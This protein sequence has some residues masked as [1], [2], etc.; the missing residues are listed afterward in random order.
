M[1][2]LGVRDMSEE[3]GKKR[4]GR[5]KTDAERLPGSKPYMRTKE[6]AEAVGPSQP[7][8][9]GGLRNEGVLKGLRGY[10]GKTPVFSTKDICSLWMLHAMVSDPDGP[11][12]E[13]WFG[14]A[15]VRHVRDRTSITDPETG[16]KYEG[17]KMSEGVVFGLLDDWADKGYA[18]YTEG[19]TSKFGTVQ[20]NYRLTANGQG[21]Y[22]VLRV[23][24]A[25]NVRAIAFM[26]NA[27]HA[28]LFG[29]GLLGTP[30]PLGERR[31][32]D[33]LDRPLPMP[34]GTKKEE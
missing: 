9:R 14:R 28:D 23:E 33:D 30:V 19:G 31:M 7:G 25:A 13:G 27:L 24:H 4:T 5:R 17:Y 18:T 11:E 6:A 21:Y 16:E 1:L 12:G 2:Y 3:Q 26:M 22:N 10:Q 15:L 29:F 32:A 34:G 20:K 8:A